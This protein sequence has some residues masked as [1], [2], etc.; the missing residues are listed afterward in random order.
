[1]RGFVISNVIFRSI[2]HSLDKAYTPFEVLK[3]FQ[4]R[5]ESCC[6]MYCYIDIIAEYLFKVQGFLVF[7]IFLCFF[8]WFCL[9]KKTYFLNNLYYKTH[10]LT[11]WE[12]TLKK[13]L[14]HKISANSQSF[15]LCGQMGLLGSMKMY[16]KFSLRYLPVLGWAGYLAE[17]PFLRRDREKGI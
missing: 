14:V 9:A 1:M 16:C 15:Q 5:F 11:G 4:N 6:I 8:S 13:S 2:S 10:A 17:S 7:F 12:I 3:N